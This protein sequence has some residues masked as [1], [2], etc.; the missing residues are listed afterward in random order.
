MAR[1]TPGQ[2]IHLVG[3]GGAG[4]SAIARVLLGLGYRVSGSDRSASSL[5]DALAQA[6][7]QVFIGH[8][9]AYIAG[10]DALII[11]SAVGADH[12]EVAAAR[13]A[14]V[15][16]YKRQDIIAEL[17]AGRQ[18]V[19]VAGTH[20]KTTTTSLIVHLL[21]AC[22]CRPG[23]IVGGV[24][25]S[26]GVNAEVGSDPLFVIE[27]DEYDN[28]YHGLR[29]D[30]AVVTNVE[31]DHPDFFASPAA[32]LESF[33]IFVGRLAARGGTLV[34]GSDDAG[35]RRLADNARAAG[36]RVVTYGLEAGADWR[37]V[38]LRIEPGGGSRFVVVASDGQRAGARLPLP[39]VHNVANALGALAA[40]QAAGAADLADTLAGLA[41]FMPAGRRFDLRADVGGVAVIDD[42]AHHP[43]AI[44]ATL[45]AARGRYPDR[46][47]WAVWQPHTYSRTRALRAD[48]LRAFAAADH[49][50]V[51]DIYAARERPLPGVTSADLVAAMAHPDARHTP[52]LADAVQALAAGVRPPAVVIIM[53]A[54]DAPQIGVE[55]LRLLEQTA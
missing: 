3:I 45:A 34:A 4:L 8:D 2:H 7:A 24:M 13:A 27:A 25:G 36:S 31:Y 39:G 11:T 21:H 49:V 43:T 6:G 48:Y 46:D 54:G 53:S 32:L 19:A 16:V 1:L 47:I 50:L 26:T 55:F 33:Q 15:P 12:V 41:T 29:P 17:M 20:G 30:V 42:Y 40:V 35:A 10:A 52:A 5:T 18:V 22:G 23:Y 37:A 28:M 51:T 14:G 44:R 9:A 38:E